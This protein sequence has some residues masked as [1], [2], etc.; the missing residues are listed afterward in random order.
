[1]NPGLF[2]AACVPLWLGVSNCWSQAPPVL[3]TDH[4]T[5]LQFNGFH[6]KPPGGENWYRFIRNDGNVLFGKRIDSKVHTFAALVHSGMLPAGIAVGSIEDYFALVKKIKR[7]MISPKYLRF[8]EEEYVTE[9]TPGRTCI[10]YRLKAE[11]ILAPQARGVPLT[12]EINGFSCTHP[13]SLRTSIDIHYSERG[14]PGPD[15]EG[16]RREGE[17][18]IRGIVFTPLK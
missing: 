4:D 17:E 5:P 14:G 12:L 2:L 9:N 3:V 8:L 7:A 10:R 6:V 11:A 1:M 13:E 18:F 16:M 15:S